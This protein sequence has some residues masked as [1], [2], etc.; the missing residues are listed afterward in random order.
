M[1]AHEFVVGKWYKTHDGRYGKFTKLSAGYTQE[2]NRYFH[3]SELIDNNLNHEFYDG[4]WSRSDMVREI[5]ISE[6]ACQLP[7]NIEIEQGYQ[8]Y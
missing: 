8:I 4:N 6:I 5:D 2:P 1:E 3:F 7:Y